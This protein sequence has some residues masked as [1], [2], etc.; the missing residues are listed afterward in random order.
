MEENDRIKLSEP[1]FCSLQGEGPYSGTP[2]LFIRTSRCILTCPFCDTKFAWKDGDI[3]ITV[4]D[5]LDELR[6]KK[7][8]NHI[9]ITGGEPLLECN[10]KKLKTFLDALSGFFYITFETTL[11]SGKNVLFESTLRNELFEYTKFF[12]REIHYVISPK[13]DPNCYPFPVIKENIFRFYGEYLNGYDACF[14]L[15]YDKNDLDILEFI[16]KPKVNS[17][18]IWI[19]PMTPI[20]FDKD[21][22][23]KSCENTAEFCIKKG[24]KYSPRIHI[25]IWGNERGK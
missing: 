18:D 16:E 22:Y 15:I 25:D 6:K 17:N 20:P 10:H 13:F 21:L 12:K 23:K 9:V 11:L 2:S 1:I 19:M 8:I 4:K 3:N 7:T 24:L 14:K 5:I